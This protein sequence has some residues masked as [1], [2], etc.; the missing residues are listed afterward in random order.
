MADTWV[1][2]VTYNEAANLPLVLEAVRVALPEAGIIVVDDN[3]P[4]GTAS[5]A[6]ER[7]ARDPGI[8]VIVRE[9]KL[10]YASAQR[11]AIDFAV[12][13]GAA[14]VVTMDADLSHDPAALTA[15]VA[16]LNDADMAIG[17]RYVPGGATVGWPVHR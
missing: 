17:S 4:D 12:A 1:C 3:S 7:A 15:L 14:R 5:L 11:A 8:H 13:Q 10:G 9:G 2:L 16:A 6:R